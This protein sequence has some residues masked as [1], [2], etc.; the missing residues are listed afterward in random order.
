MRL[1]VKDFMT[2]SVLTASAN[3]SIGDVRALMKREGIHALPI[4]EAIPLGALNIRGIITATDLCTEMDDSL[5]V[6]QVLKPGLVHVIPPNTNAQSAAKNM[7]KHKV[8]HLVVM[9]DGKII[10]MISSQDFVKLV[11]NYALDK[12]ADTVI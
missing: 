2:T 1:Q 9:E 5:I 6:E 12:K 7:L 8:H 3:T 11:A 10:G 4:V